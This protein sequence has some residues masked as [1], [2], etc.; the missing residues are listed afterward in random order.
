MWT[1]AVSLVVVGS[2]LEQPAE[3]PEVWIDRVD[4]IPDLAQASLAQT[5]DAFCAPAAVTNSLSFLAA[6]GYPRLVEGDPGDE[7][8]QLAVARTL[9]GPGYM[10]TAPDSGTSKERLIA[11]VHD[12][13]RDRGYRVHAIEY[14]GIEVY[15]D[16]ER[17]L[18]HSAPD[19]A[20]IR[21]GL[22][23]G[24][25]CWLQIGW[26]RRIGEDYRKTG[27]HWVTLTG[28]GA[29]AGG[30]PDAS[31]LVIRDPSPR[32]GNGPTSEVLRCRALDHGRIRGWG[33][34]Q[35]AAGFTDVTEGIAL[36]EDAELAILEGAVIMELD[37]P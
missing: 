23:A 24:A 17:P 14:L 5:G 30:T 25:S 15:Y 26:Y 18:G 37:P 28:Y 12:Y 9:A 6:N 29:D 7:T 22:A 32:A 3:F 1:V 20:Q 4:R 34:P 19:L 35:P 11:G 33:L 8:N 31:V 2:V 16:P 21:S 13:V 27:G 36:H 10:Q